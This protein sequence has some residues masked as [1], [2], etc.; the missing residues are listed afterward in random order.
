MIIA[1][2]LI[3][4]Y[5]KTAGLAGPFPVRGSTTEGN[6]MP[7]I[8]FYLDDEHYKKYK[9]LSKEKKT[10]INAK[11]RKGYYSELDKVR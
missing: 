2:N 6:N 7:D 10:E 5:E 3:F 9:T 11:V 4:S 1:R 8:P